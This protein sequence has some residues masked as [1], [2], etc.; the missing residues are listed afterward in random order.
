LGREFLLPLAVP[1]SFAID[2]LAGIAGALA[3]VGEGEIALLQ[4]IFEP[5]RHAWAESIARSVTFSDGSPLFNGMRDFLAQSEEKVSR[6]LYA[7]IVR[8]AC[9]SIHEVRA[10]DLAK[11]LGGSLAP[12]N[13]PEGNELIPLA[14]DDYDAEAHAEDVVRRRS[15]RCG[16]IINS[17][18]LINLVHLPSASVRIPKLRGQAKKTMPAPSLVSGHTLI[19]GINEHVGETRMVSLSPEQRTKHMH[20]IG[21][22][23]TGKSTLLLNLIAQDIRNGDGLAVLDPHGDLVDSVLRLIPP[24]RVKDVILLDPSDDEYPI[25]FNVLSAHSAMEKDLLAS[26]L[27]AVF[28]RLST[29]WGD[30]MNAVLA[31]AIL[32]F[33]ESDQGG[34]LVDLRRFLVEMAYRKRYLRTVKD[35]E[36]VYYWTKEFPLLT[37]RPQGPV[38]TRL[39]TFLRPKPIRYMVAQKESR[40]DFGSIL[41]TGKILLARLS[42]GAIGAENSHLLGALLVS[43]LHQLALGRQRQREEDRRFFWLYVDEFHHFATPSMA[44]ILSGARKYRLGLILAHQNL[45]QLENV[46][47]VASAVQNSYTRVCFRLSDQDAKKLESGFADFTALDLQNLST[48]EAICRVERADLDFNLRTEIPPDVPDEDAQMVKDAI[49]RHTSD[50]YAVPRAAVE[51]ALAH[52]KREDEDGELTETL[53][54]GAEPAARGTKNQTDK[55]A[56]ILPLPTETPSQRRGAAKTTN[57]VDEKSALEEAPLSG[58]GGKEHQ[59]IQRLIKEWAEGRGYRATIEAQTLGTRAADIALEKEG[60]SIACEICVTTGLVVHRIELVHVR[61]SRDP[62]QREFTALITASARDFY[63]DDRTGKFIR[64]DRSSAQFQ[65][66]WIFHFLSRRWLLRE[67]EQSR[68]SDALR[69]KNVVEQMTAEQMESVAGPHPTAPPPP[70]ADPNVTDKISRVEQQLTQLASRDPMWERSI[71]T[72]RARDIFILLMT[73]EESGNPQSVTADDLLPDA[74]LKV[75]GVISHRHQAGETVQY[76]NLCVRK[77]ELVLARSNPDQ[78]LARV[79]GHAQ[80]IISRD[81][82]VIRQDPYEIP[83]VQFLL[84]EL[85]ASKWKLKDVMPPGVGAK[86]MAADHSV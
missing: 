18:E 59:R 10:W 41:D 2:P 40:L 82:S 37:G 57:A 63:V 45:Q 42:Q 65:E 13:D 7:C 8:I 61:Y 85:T 25:G 84:F 34:T 64:G 39:D 4:V 46:P 77:V 69:E 16:M 5:V 30:Q 28:H 12:L 32:A 51:A 62:Q 35:P 33:L 73:S 14:N 19:L 20:V 83:F 80:T 49:V 79:T 27:V 66:F 53:N 58:R 52:S 60:I 86:A 81:F 70:W 74:L 9:R 67:I 76:R 15:R 23:G 44:A 24:E 3:D 21:A 56:E 31:N 50:R 75:R 55:A 17:E 22:S 6:P 71:L 43:K 1:R 26:D 72:S 11:R 38:L 54:E 48:G 29:S 47:E 68:E 36:V 78:F